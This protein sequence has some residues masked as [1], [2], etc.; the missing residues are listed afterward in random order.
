MTEAEDPP[1]SP[2]R[3]SAADR[4]DAKRA[5][6]APPPKRSP[7]QAKN[8]PLARISLGVGIGSAALAAAVIFVARSRNRD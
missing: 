7:A 3:S 4:K 5:G 2:T 8:W 6:R 1:K